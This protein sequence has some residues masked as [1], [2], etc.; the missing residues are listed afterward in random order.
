M[1]SRLRDAIVALSCSIF[2]IVSTLGSRPLICS[3]LAGLLGLENEGHWN[4]PA[5]RAGSAKNA[6]SVRLR[7]N[8]VLIMMHLPRPG[9]CTFR[10]Q[11]FCNRTCRRGSKVALLPHQIEGEENSEEAIRCGNG[12][13][14]GRTRQLTEECQYE[15]GQLLDSC[16][17]QDWAA[18]AGKKRG[19]D[20]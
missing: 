3:S 18:G 19:V 11:M 13:H 10:D 5:P 15:N 12:S 20:R 6:Q 4:C 1:P 17:C 2:V 14:R 9:C 8:A 7:P 16:C